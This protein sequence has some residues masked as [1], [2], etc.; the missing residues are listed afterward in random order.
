[1]NKVIFINIFFRF[2][3]S[4]NCNANCSCEGVSYSPVCHEETDTTYF[5][6]CHAGCS[7]WDPETKVYNN[8]SCLT[9]TLKVLPKFGA[10][11]QLIQGFDTTVRPIVE[12]DL[13]TGLPLMGMPDENLDLSS[14]PLLND[15]YSAE[16][17]DDILSRSKRAISNL[18]L[19]P[20]VCLKGCNTAFLT[21]S[22][23]SLLINWIGCSGR[24]GTILVNYRAV[25]TEDKSF[26]QGLALMML[27]LFALIPGPIIFGRIIDA[28]CLVWTE[29]C[30][31]IGNCQLHDQ[32]KFRFSVNFVSGRKCNFNCK[33]T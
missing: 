17:D 4:T 3:L 27:S 19:E 7:S 8:C 31:G 12:L 32:T 20:G 15:D 25:S 14:V 6:A 33:E 18:V 10:P 1:V 9:E 5:S 24:I 13:N 28:T 11:E 29:T 23:T 21:F 16:I 30:N 26:A 22:I 2:N